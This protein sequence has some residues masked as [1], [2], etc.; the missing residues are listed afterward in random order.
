MIPNPVQFLSY[1]A[2]HTHHIQL[3]TAVIVLPWHDPVRIAEEIALLDVMSGGR[4]IYGFGRGAGSV[5]YD[6]LRVPMEE[7]RDRFAEMANIVRMALT[8]PRFSYDGRF[9]KIPETCDPAAVRSP[10]RWSAFTPPR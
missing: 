7:S 1:F 10:I 6:G 2:A 3:G 5:E 8:Q 4:T 9:Y